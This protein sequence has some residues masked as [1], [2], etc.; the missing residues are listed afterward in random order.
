MTERSALKYLIG[1]CEQVAA[2]GIMP[3][4]GWFAE[5]AAELA[6]L[7]E[8]SSP[9]FQSCQCPAKTGENCPL[10]LDECDARTA[11]YIGQP[12]F[13]ARLRR[14][15][16]GFVQESANGVVCSIPDT[17]LNTPTHRPW[18][19]SRERATPDSSEI[20][21]ENGTSPSRE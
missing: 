4:R 11:D 7:R 8:P 19:E 2:D 10:T 16:D 12:W 20:I 21:K 17:G 13:G 9:R 3:S 14:I 18:R 6:K 15:F 1:F 5:A